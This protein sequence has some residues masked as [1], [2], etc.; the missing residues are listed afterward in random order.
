MTNSNK[1]TIEALNI[2]LADYHLH[3]QKLRNFHWNITGPHFFELHAKFEEL[4]EDA[5]LKID[6]IAERILTLRGNPVSNFSAYLNLSNIKEADSTLIDQKMVSEILEDHIAL[7]K[8]LKKVT[9]S[10]EN[11]KDDGTLDITGTYIGEIEKTSWMLNA[12]NQ[13]K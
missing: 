10:A 11:A 13:R 1:E 4:Y 9:A 5:K 6:E 12:W 8:Q 2:L 7:L 3:Y